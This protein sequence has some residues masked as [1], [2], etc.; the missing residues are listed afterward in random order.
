M[1]CQAYSILVPLMG[2]TLQGFAP[3]VDAVRPLERRL[4]PGVIRDTEYPAP[5]SGLFT[6]TRVPHA[7]LGFSQKTTPDAPLGLV[8]VEASYPWQRSK[9]KSK[10]T[11]PLTRFFDT[12]AS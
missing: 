1:T 2:L 12:A 11:I 10:P 3:L 4:P 7:A 6:P 8:P 9:T 5:P